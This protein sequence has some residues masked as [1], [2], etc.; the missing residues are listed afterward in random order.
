MTQST[1]FRVKLSLERDAGASAD[2]H[3]QIGDKSESTISLTNTLRMKEGC[4]Q[5][6]ASCVVD[7]NGF[8]SCHQYFEE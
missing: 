4:S 3:G 8:E 6:M 2:A 5:E 7:R 1:Y